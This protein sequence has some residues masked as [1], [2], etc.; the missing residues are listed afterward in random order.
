MS[1][2]ATSGHRGSRA[3]RWGDQP[4][5]KGSCGVTGSTDRVRGGNGVVTG[6]RARG[7]D[8]NRPEAGVQL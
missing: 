3:D 4:V 2:S 8:R 6:P 7:T 5:S 1:A